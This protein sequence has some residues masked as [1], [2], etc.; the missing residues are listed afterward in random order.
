MRERE[1]ND[2]D[3]N[4]DEY[5]SHGHI[6]LHDIDEQ[7]PFAGQRPTIP[8][9]QVFSKQV[10]SKSEEGNR[11][12]TPRG[13][14]FSQDGQ[15]HSNMREAT[16]SKEENVREYDQ[17]DKQHL[18]HQKH[19]IVLDHLTTRRAK[20][21]LST[22]ILIKHS[23]IPSGIRFVPRLQELVQNPLYLKRLKQFGFLKIHDVL[24]CYRCWEFQQCLFS[25][26]QKQRF[27]QS[28]DVYCLNCAEYG[29]SR[30]LQRDL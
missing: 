30:V 27:R 29:S 25:K 26:H 15:Q 2:G 6:D 5:V 7:R 1:L 13:K 9:H 23:T 21:V 11:R 22:D 19:V 17:V 24:H 20:P 8:L 3:C 4:K 12:P 18:L 10:F 16:P 28:H 14:P